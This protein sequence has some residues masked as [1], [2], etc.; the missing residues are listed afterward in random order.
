[1]K[2]TKVL[3]VFASLNMGGAESRMMDIYRNI[4]RDEVEFVF[5]T[6]TKDD[7]QY[8]EK[9][10]VKRNSLRSNGSIHDGRLWL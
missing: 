10:I 3:Q 7:N 9:E 4:V 6:L 5:L 8:Y 2:K 1:M